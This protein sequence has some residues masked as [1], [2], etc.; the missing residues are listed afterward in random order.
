MGRTIHPFQAK[1]SWVYSVHT[2]RQ[3]QRNLKKS[4]T[5]VFH[6]E[7][8]TSSKLCICESTIQIN[9]YSLQNQFH[10][11]QVSPIIKYTISD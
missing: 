8:V 9:L 7:V 5:F 1:Y 3:W 6:P 11:M 10:K 4:A 2:P